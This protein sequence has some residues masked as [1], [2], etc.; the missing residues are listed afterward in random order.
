MKNKKIILS[1]TIIIGIL[2]FILLLCKGVIRNQFELSKMKPLK[3]GE[4]ISDIYSI[5]NGFVNLFLLKGSNGYLMIDAGNDKEQTLRELERLGIVQEDIKAVLL[6]HSDYDHVTALSLFP[7]A[8]VYLPADELQM[9][10]GITSRGGSYNELEREYLILQDKDTV[11]ILDFSVAC[12]A[13]PGHT[14][15]SMSY[16]ID[17]KYLFVGDSMRL[18]DGK[19]TLF[20]SYFNMDDTKQKVSIQLLAQLHPECIFTAHYGYSDDPNLAFEDWRN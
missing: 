2:L 10:N 15:G 8:Q 11:R 4:V 19:A 1:V 7:N 14:P 9:I 5:N 20:N 12:I 16:F 6:T 18:K 17:E 3:T 13:T